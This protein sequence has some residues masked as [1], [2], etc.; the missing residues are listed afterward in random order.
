MDGVKVF[1]KA[2]VAQKPWLRDPLVVRKK[3]DEDEYKLI[4]HGGGKNMCFGILW[5]DGNV[6]PHP[7]VTRGL[8]ITMKALVAAGH[9]VIDWKP[10]KHVELF[11]A[12]KG[13][14]GAG[15]EEDYR[16][17]IASAGEPII[18]TMAP[19]PS[20]PSTD[21]VTSSENGTSAY[22]L[23]Q[24][25]KLRR[26]MR[27]EYLDHWESTVH[28]TGTGRPVDAII[29][30][31]APYAAPP[32]GKNRN[33]AYTAV[34]NGLDYT[35]S[36]FPVTV[37]NPAVDVKKPAHAFLSK[38][39]EWTY[40]LC[41]QHVPSN[42]IAML[43]ILPSFLDDPAT[44]KGARIALQLVGRTLEEEAVI[45]MTEVVDEA[46]KKLQASETAAL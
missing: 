9:K 10:L 25:Q 27:R 28:L 44:F 7:P 45:A 32:H 26:D 39:D 41:A 12:L 35:A 37:V 3:W 17:T 13:I 22:Q 8:E 11:A 38:A 30:P 19:D 2:I 33:A 36:V 18:R 42:T 31:V 43:D 6:V 23:W 1:M 21:F 5:D 20:S 34:W 40:N 15:S 14:W 29:A 4:D 24:L 16:T 46:V